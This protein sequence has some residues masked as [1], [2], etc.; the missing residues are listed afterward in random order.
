MPITTI[1]PIPFVG[2]ITLEKD[3]L[4]I[5]FRNVLINLNKILIL[6]VIITPTRNVSRLPHSYTISFDIIL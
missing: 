2:S 3:S 6:G 4:T 5:P 1:I